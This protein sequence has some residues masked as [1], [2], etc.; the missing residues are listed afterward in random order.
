V[1]V[2]FYMDHNVQGAV[3]DALRVRGVD[4]LTAQE[5]GTKTLE[6]DS[7]LERATKLG[8]VLVMHD[9]DFFAIFGAWWAAGR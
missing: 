4:C 6:D 1:S 5:D 3:V 8:R 2:R 9:K 7:V